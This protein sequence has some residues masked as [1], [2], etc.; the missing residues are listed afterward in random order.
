MYR[1]FLAL[2][3]LLQ[4]PIN[5]LGMLGVMLGV[6]ALI[7]VVSIF[8]GYIAEV[9]DH[10]RA[11][12][13]DVTVF[14]LSPD[15]SFARV[16]KIVEADANVLHCAPRMAWVGLLHPTTA[17]APRPPDLVANAEIGEDS[18][19]VHLLGVD[20]QAELQ[21]SGLRD[22][23]AAVEAPE[24]RVAPETLLAPRGEQ[25]ALLL[26]ER[27]LQLEGLVPGDKVRVTCARLHSRV[28]QDLEAEDLDYAVQGAF[29]SKYVLFDASTTF[30]HIDTLRR[31]LATSTADACNVVAVR[32]RD[33][34]TDAATAKRLE[35]ALSAEFGFDLYVQ[36][37]EQTNAT[38]L[39]AVDHQRSLMKLVLFVIMVV[40]AFLMF[41]TL[42]M[43]VT[44][45]VN[46]IGILT[47][48]GANRR[49]VMQVF[50]S[51]GLAI[52]GVGT[53]LGIGLGC[54]SAMYLDAFNTWVRGAFDVDLFP[55]TI[56]NLK[57][58]PYALDPVWIGQVA[59]MAMGVSVVVSALPAWR[60]ARH[61]PIASLRED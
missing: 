48:M 1:W 49:G 4:R 11:T 52:A 33:P 29:A 46:D 5:L 32:L 37:W 19:F 8:S 17:K 13:A 36:N 39:S 44:E 34:S 28:G 9:R 47:A 12:T 40:A 23:L 51:C 58:V 15:S 45:K 60:A 43:M 7:V 42:S 24:V 57:R 59:S 53:A 21:V 22:W 14:G 27:R 31:L 20:P 10:I 18:R 3:Y 30:V 55:T 38:F 41:A 35:R 6:W 50:L 26:S 16:R 56:Y 2:R 61:D 54:L 25:P